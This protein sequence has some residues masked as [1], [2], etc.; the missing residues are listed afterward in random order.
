MGSGDV[1]SRVLVA[2]EPRLL[3]DVLAQVLSSAG[4]VVVV[5]EPEATIDLVGDFDAAV[6]TIDLP[7]D[8]HADVVIHLPD[9]FGNVGTGA[10]T[11]AACRRNVEIMGLDDIL[12][13]I[14]DELI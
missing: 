7:A 2:V 10:V 9:D 14:R 12:L 11:R 6:V 13:L 4:D 1:R 5:A 8:V 3:G